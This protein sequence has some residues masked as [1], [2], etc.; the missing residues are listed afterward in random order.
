MLK[1]R[2]VVRYRDGRRMKGF[3]WDFLPTKEVFH[4]A[5]EK[6]E[7]KISE[8]STRDLKAVFFVKTFDGD[9]NRQWSRPSD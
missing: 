6:D 3:T 7:K 9:K 4:V 1:N 5:D 8:V 2:V